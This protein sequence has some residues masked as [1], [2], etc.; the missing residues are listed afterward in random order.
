MCNKFHQDKKKV[1]EVF[2]EL[3]ESELRKLKMF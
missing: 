1:D 2:W 3:N